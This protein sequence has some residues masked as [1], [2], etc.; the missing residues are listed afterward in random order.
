[1]AEA[2]TILEAIRDVSEK[3]IEALNQEESKS[4]DPLLDKRADLIVELMEAERNDEKPINNLV[5]AVEKQEKTMLKMMND[6]ASEYKKQLM[7]MYK[8]KNAMTKGYY[9]S[10]ESGIAKGHKYSAERKRRDF[11]GRG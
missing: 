3:I 1:M 11:S 8:G 2:R 10:S 9:K 5:R 6:R 4:L 7:T